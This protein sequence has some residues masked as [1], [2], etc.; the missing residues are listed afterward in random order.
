MLPISELIGHGRIHII[1]YAKW[2]E[3]MDMPQKVSN[4]SLAKHKYLKSQS[5]LAKLLVAN[6]I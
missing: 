4:A 5:N 6:L 1:D 3:K 2:E